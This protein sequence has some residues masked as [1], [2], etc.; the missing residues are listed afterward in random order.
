MRAAA[1]FESQGTHP[2]PRQLFVSQKETVRGGKTHK[3]TLQLR[4]YEKLSYPEN[5]PYDKAQHDDKHDHSNSD[6]GHDH[7]AQRGRLT[8]FH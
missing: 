3:H 2:R 8:A 5:D 6:G 7:H 1:L 4:L